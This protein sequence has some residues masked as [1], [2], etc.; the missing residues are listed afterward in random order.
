MKIPALKS[1]I[2]TIS[3]YLIPVV[4]VSTLLTF[5]AYADNSTLNKELSATSNQSNE[6]KKKL[7]LDF[8]NEE[9]HEKDSVKHLGIRISADDEE[10]TALGGII[11]KLVGTEWDQLDES[12]QKE[13]LE[14]LEQIETGVEIDID[15][16]GFGPGK[17]LVSVVAILSTLGMPF[18]IIGLI[19][20][21]KHRKRRQRD[22]LI[23]KFIDAGKDIPVEILQGS[24]GSDEPQGNFQRG[25]MLTG[26]GI[27]LLLFLGI[28][29]GWDVASVAL[30][31][32]FIG[33]ARLLIWKLSTQDKSVEGTE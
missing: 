21:Y 3:L 27:G 22:L 13:I 20:F 12:E 15:H 11:T 23:S 2:L 18:I 7:I 4:M 28:L 16:S 6:H 14:A 30:I 33:L 1:L 26:I 19:L 5:P 17:V 32:L 29:V 9:V 31:P 25:I 8:E 24:D 10:L